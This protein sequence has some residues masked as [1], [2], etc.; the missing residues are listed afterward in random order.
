MRSAIF[1]AVL[2]LG[3]CTSHGEERDEPRATGQRSFQVGQF[4]A[5]SLEG[6]HDVVVTVGGA[7]SVRAEGD[8]RRRALASERGP[9]LKIGSHVALVT[10][11]AKAAA[12]PS[13]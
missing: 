4:Q 5:V 3:A 8:S 2:V 12:S 1:G 9:A 10:S 6:S 7:P 13:T 11:A